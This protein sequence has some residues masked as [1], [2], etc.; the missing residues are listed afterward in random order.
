MTKMSKLVSTP[1]AQAY[2]GPK[3]V[4]AQQEYLSKH[5]DYLK[6]VQSS[7][8]KAEDAR[9]K[10]QNAFLAKNNTTSLG[11]LANPFQKSM[12][13][14]KYTAEDRLIISQLVQG[15]PPDDSLAYDDPR[16]K[17]AQ[18][19]RS[20]NDQYKITTRDDYIR[21]LQDFVDWFVLR[22]VGY[23]GNPT[24][25]A[26]IAAKLYNK[27]AGVG[28]TE[29][30]ASVVS[31]NL[32]NPAATSIGQL[33]PTQKKKILTNANFLFSDDIKAYIQNQI[34]KPGG[35]GYTEVGKLVTNQPVAPSK[36]TLPVPGYNPGTD[37]LLKDLVQTLKKIYYEKKNSVDVE[38][39]T[40][41]KSIDYLFPMWGYGPTDESVNFI[42]TQ[43]IRDS[44]LDYKVIDVIN[45]ADDND[46]GYVEWVGELIKDHKYYRFYGWDLDDDGK[47]LIMMGKTSESIG[48]IG[49]FVSFMD[50]LTDALYKLYNRTMNDRLKDDVRWA[51]NYIYILIEDM[52][53][54]YI[55]LHKV[56]F[57]RLAD[58]MF[59][60]LRDYIDKV[61]S[62]RTSIES[63]MAPAG[64][65]TPAGP[66][67]PAGPSTPAIGDSSLVSDTLETSTPAP[68]P[69]KPDTDDDSGK[70]DT[71]VGSG[72]GKGMKKALSKEIQKI[73]AYKHAGGNNK[74]V[75]AKVAILRR[76]VR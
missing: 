2:Y 74:Q 64:P 20:F 32:I 47:N 39:D 9:I 3:I 5:K 1:Y 46:S 6:M 65:S 45:Y 7:T 57:V 62:L 76:M 58:S 34:Y 43:T 26:V 50:R 16:R 25:T 52:Y 27:T 23:P 29:I 69:A 59:Q 14:L 38:D 73:E 70:P 72:L 48:N 11:M 66:S 55:S 28:A 10:M 54:L 36:T 56:N 18:F 60:K 21:L 15:V 30:P 67:I 71:D 13:P 53:E 33:T 41:T 61:Y 44:K 35:T 17:L 40:D 4:D 24:G 19:L 63:K 42:N 22:D 49:E 75:A 31:S 51:M 12:Q 37:I 8:D 68:T